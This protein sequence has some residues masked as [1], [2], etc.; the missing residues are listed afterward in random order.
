MKIVISLMLLLTGGGLI[1]YFLSS[2]VEIP[3]WK[4]LGAF[5]LLGL[6]GALIGS[7]LHKGKTSFGFSF[8]YQ[9]WLYGAFTLLG[10]YQLLFVAYADGM[11]SLAIALVFDPFNPDEAWSA[12][13]LGQK[14]WLLIHLAF[15]MSLFVLLF[16]ADFGRVFEHGLWQVFTR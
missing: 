5:A 16:T 8:H 1:G 10:L 15:I 2:S 7:I 3:L 9:P 4:W 11:G 6:G 13:P 14:I 12:R